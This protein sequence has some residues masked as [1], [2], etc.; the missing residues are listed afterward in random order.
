MMVVEPQPA[1][2]TPVALDE[3]KAFLRLTGSDEDAL[4]GGFVRTA[5]ALAEA[6]TSQQLIV[7]DVTER[8][9]ASAA[10][11]RLHGLPVVAVTGVANASGPLGGGAYETDIDLD[12]R[13]W[14]RIVDLASI[15]AVVA[16]ITEPY[17]DYGGSGLRVAQRPPPRVMVSYRAGL[18]ADWN[19]VPE[20]LRQG[21]TRLVAHLYTH[22]DAADAGG[23][24]AA[25]AAL[26]RPWRRMRIR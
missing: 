19:G 8:L 23:P 5:T 6:F 14:V 15:G 20:P 22:R 16:D 26:W 3:V 13:G 17:A 1:A 10:W 24:P 21:I 9:V 4:L 11:Q 12:G 7:R 25:V 18:A 2:A